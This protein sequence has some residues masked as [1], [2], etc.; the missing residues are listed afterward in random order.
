MAIPIKLSKRVVDQTLP[1]SDGSKC[2]FVWDSDVKGFG[3]RVM[4][5]GTKSY[6]F[7]YRASGGRTRRKTVGKH[8]SITVDQ[9]REIA[10][11]WYV[12]V[13]SGGDPAA[14]SRESR[15]APT[16]EHLCERYLNEHA[17]RNKRPRSVEGDTDYIARFIKPQLG[18]KKVSEIELTD[19]ERLADSL[20]DR[21]TT[22]N[23]LVALLSKM[24]NL[25]R[26][27]NWCDHNPTEGWQKNPETKRERY[28]SKDELGRLV[29]AMDGNANQ[30]G[31][32]IVRILLLTGAR[33]GEV[34][35][36]HWADVD[37]SIGRWTKPAHTT[38]QKRTEIIPLSEAAIA[39]LR[40][41]R[42]KAPADNVYVFPGDVPGKPMTTIKTFWRSL[43][44]EANIDDVRLHDLRHTFA[45]HLVSS[46]ESLE[47]I[48]RLL[49]HS[50]P[51]TTARYAHLKD[52]ALRKATNLF[53]DASGYRPKARDE[54]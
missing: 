26:R 12:Q 25:A 44:K 7:Q 46:G 51:Q 29:T 39:L 28:L 27:W 48:G 11:D 5:T 31:C 18:R 52:E 13:R 42:H 15:N 30:R 23:R 35:S 49:G 14:E 34:F 1:P 4:N 50:Q 10:R 37:L 6:V 53:S 36:M 38:K 32:N 41:I 8:G 2:T 24:F 54:N 47:T 9:A 45:S 20:G 33:R 3:L 16:V 19:I 43:R 17:K 21:R 40:Q 22:A